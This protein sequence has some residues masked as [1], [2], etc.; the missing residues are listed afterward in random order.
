MQ[1][2]RERKQPARHLVLS[3]GAPR[4]TMSEVDVYPPLGHG[5][6]KRTTESLGTRTEYIYMIT[7]Y[8]LASP[9]KTRL[10]VNSSLGSC[11]RHT[12][13]RATVTENSGCRSHLATVRDATWKNEYRL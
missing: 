10:T 1:V 4:R 6:R 9:F 2:A 8:P 3:G 7:E 12:P 5:Q 13:P 11:S